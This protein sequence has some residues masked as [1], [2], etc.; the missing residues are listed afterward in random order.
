MSLRFVH[1]GLLLACAVSSSL[2]AQSY[3]IRREPRLRVEQATPR[4]RPLEQR[5]DNPLSDTRG[6]NMP[7]VAWW[8]LYP[9]VTSGAA[10]G[11]HKITR[12]PP[13]ASA[14]IAAV[15]IGLVPHLRGYSRGA[16][17]INPGD[18]TFDAVNRALPVFAMS[19]RRGVVAWTASVAVLSCFASP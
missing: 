7:A 18:W 3:F 19:E 11:I 1:S 13:K 10:Y 12:L 9:V 17:P 6:W 4:C 5:F 15:A 2:G 8:T 16:Y 14:V